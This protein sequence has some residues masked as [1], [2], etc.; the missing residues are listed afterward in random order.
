MKFTQ[1]VLIQCLKDEFE[2]PNGEFNI[3]MLENSVLKD[4]DEV[5]NAAEQTKHRSGVGKPLH[6]TRWSRPEMFNL[7][8]EST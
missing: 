1:P 4:A 8:H 7:V 2:L 3:P 5:L 6:L